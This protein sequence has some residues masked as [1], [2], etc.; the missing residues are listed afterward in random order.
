MPLPQAQV[1]RC[2]PA[3]EPFV[4]RQPV[5]ALHHQ[6]SEAHRA[7]VV[8]LVHHVVPSAGPV[9]H[10]L[11]DALRRVLHPDREPAVG[12]A[13]FPVRQHARYACYVVPLRVHQHFPDEIPVHVRHARVQDQQVVRLRGCR[14]LVDQP[15]PLFFPAGH[16][17]SAELRPVG[18]ELQFA[19]ALPAFFLALPVDD[20]LDRRVRR[21]LV[22]Q[23]DLLIHRHG[24]SFPPELALVLDRCPAS[25]VQAGPQLPVALAGEDFPPAVQDVGE[26]LD[27]LRLLRQAEEEIVILAPVKA[28]AQPGFLQQLPP[29]HRHV[30]QVVVAHQVVRAVVGLVVRVHVA[31][32]VLCD[33]VLVGVDHVRVLFGDAFRRPPQG[34]RGQQVVVVTQGGVFALRRLHGLVRVSADALVLRSPDH[35]EHRGTGL[36]C[37]RLQPGQHL[38]RSRLCAR[39]VVQHGLEVPVGLRLDAAE[40]GPQHDRVRVVHRDHQADQPGL[41]LI[42]PLPLKFRLRGLLPPP[43]PV[44]GSQQ[45]LGCLLAEPFQRVGRPVAFP[46][47]PDP[48]DR[49][50]VLSPVPDVSRK[51]LMIN[52]LRIDK[53]FYPLYT[54]FAICHIWSI[55][56]GDLP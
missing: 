54:G 37:S 26:V 44:I 13:A 47:F 23:A 15:D 38:E 25:V 18:P 34:I 56:R 2:E 1:D 36:L 41:G 51:T 6:A 55:W 4:Q 29:D 30:A 48:F 43:P 46:V 20:G 3:A 33:P 39:S 31:P 12:D 49:S 8:H 52:L 28:A 27:L 9:V 7:H 10:A 50:H 32:S 19:Q 53:P 5:R 24:L 42:L 11:V 45:L 14:G 17:A 22:P 40:Q 16:E 35:P 21:D